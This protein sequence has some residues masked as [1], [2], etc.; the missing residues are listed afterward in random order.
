MSLSTHFG[1]YYFAIKYSIE[2]LGVKDNSLNL[3]GR[4]FEM[5][6]TFIE[7]DGIKF[8]MLFNQMI[9]SN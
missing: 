1:V 8:N 2:Y 3:E 9:S 4:E 7:F 5:V 6:I